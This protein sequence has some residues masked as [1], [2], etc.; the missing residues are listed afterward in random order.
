LVRENLDTPHLDVTLGHDLAI[1]I[2]HKPQTRDINHVLCIL[3]AG[4]GVLGAAQEVTFGKMLRRVLI[5]LDSCSGVGS[6]AA[7]AGF[8][9]EWAE[10]LA[11]PAST[12]GSATA[13]CAWAARVLPVLDAERRCLA[14]LLCTKRIAVTSAAQMLAKRLSGTLT[15]A[16]ANEASCC[17]SCRS[18]LLITDECT[19]TACHVGNLVAEDARGAVNAR[20]KLDVCLPRDSMYTRLE[21][22]ARDLPRSQHVTLQT[23]AAQLGCP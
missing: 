7:T 10:P 1:V 4:Y 9:S 11:M 19:S 22:H 16:D 15:D 6:L 18:K 14:T 5:S 3:D 23:E 21:C 12:A 17:S 8:S 2:L 13:C 20:R